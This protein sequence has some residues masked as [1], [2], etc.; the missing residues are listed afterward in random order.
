MAVAVAEA[1]PL[2]MR[3]ASILGVLAVLMSAPRAAVAQV[4]ALAHANVVN[5][6]RS[7][8]QQ[9]GV[10]SAIERWENAV[11][12]HTAVPDEWDSIGRALYDVH[13]YRESIAAFERGLELRVGGSSES[14]WYIARGYA[15]LGNRK[16]ALR[17]LTHARQLGFR[18]EVAIGK[19]PAFEKY[20]ADTRFREL[21][22]PSMCTTC[23]TRTIPDRTDAG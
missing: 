16:Q 12:T 7:A 8:D 14:A 23:R 18:D 13:R 9:T 21:V 10:S 4:Q 11:A 15:Q 2:P 19:E 17:W 22:R 3:S 20:R 5:V 6:V 1:A